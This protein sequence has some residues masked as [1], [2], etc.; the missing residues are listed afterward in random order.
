MGLDRLSAAW[1][2]SYVSSAFQGEHDHD[3]AGCVFCQLATEPVSESTGVL[4][5]SEHTYLVLNAFPY[6]S[7]HLLTVPYRHVA[8][9]EELTD[10]E[11][12][13]LSGVVRRAVIALNAAYGP[14]GMN[15]GMNLGSAAGAGIPRHMHAHSLPRWNG[16]TN[17]MTSIGETRVLSESLDVTWRKVH[18]QLDARV[19]DR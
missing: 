15:V 1:R 5:R 18:A 3:S 12:L 7:G 6:G 14:D 9:L 11:Y 8:E 17:F 10:A 16:D 13:D 19:T 4:W 2:E